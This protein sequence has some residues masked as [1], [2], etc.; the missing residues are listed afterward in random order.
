[1]ADE[2]ADA[3]E[4]LVSLL[5]YPMYVVTTRANGE[6]AGCL[7]GFTSQVSIQPR[8]FLVGLSKRNHTYR[9]AQCS[10]TPCRAPVGAPAPRACRLFG[11]Q[12]G[13]RS[14][15]SR[16][17]HGGRARTDSRFS[18]TRSG[19]SS[20][21]CAPDR[22]RRPCR[23]SARARRRECAGRIRAARHVL[24]CPRSR[25]RP[26]GVIRPWPPVN[27]GGSGYFSET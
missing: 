26:R 24:R 17:A 18:P 7:V 11:S 12:T 19:G 6:S 15:S 21:R 20:A 22:R 9:V 3:F 8:R 13:D 5:D 14:T 10:E 2:T 23:V 4:Q 25:T 16:A 27:V 1:M